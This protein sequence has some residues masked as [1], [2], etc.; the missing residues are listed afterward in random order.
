MTLRLLLLS[1]AA[2]S[3]P[4]FAQDSAR[5]VGGEDIVVTAQRN[6]Q[7]DV[8]RAGQVG[9]L[10]DKPA[11]DVPF[12]I[13]SYSDALI[14]NQQPQSLGQVLENDPTIRT[15]YG[16][17]NA[18]EQFVIRGFTLF[19]D[20]VALDG[21]YGITPRQLVAPELYD[22]VQVLNG[23][24]AFLN[25]AAPGGSGI[26]GS[27]NL[28]PKRARRDLTRVTASY[29]SDSHVGASFDVA[30]RFGGGQWGLRLNGAHRRGDVAIDDENRRAT[31]LGAGLDYA[32]DG[33][34]AV[35]RSRLSEDPGRAASTQG[36][37]DEL[38][39][40]GAG[41]RR[42]LCPALDLHRARGSVRRRPR[43]VGRDQERPP[44]RPGRGPGRVGRRRL[45][46]NHR[47]C[48]RRQCNRIGDPGPAHRQ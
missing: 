33:R 9:I 32:R 7:T 15:S 38:H 29:L 14:Y 43:R 30:R 18:S 10:G 24:T 47:Q 16:F 2:V 22:S 42:Q 17:G 20:D 4:A 41:C 3:A 36:H 45:R 46:R 5:E 44:L 37:C 25:G 23:A 13:R 26:G 34:P 19:G 35:A 21:L 8:R 48:R 40:A 11:E 31:L 27:I 12:S 6:N 1:C 28:V 39:P